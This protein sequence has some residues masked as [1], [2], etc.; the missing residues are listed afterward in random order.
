MANFVYAGLVEG[1]RQEGYSLYFPD[2]PGC[3]TAGDTLHELGL[4][5]GEA[6]ALHLEG[7][8]EDGQP[9]PEA[10]D[11]SELREAADHP[12]GAVMLVPAQLDDTPVRVNVSIPTSMLSRID[13]EAEA[14]GMTRSGFLVEGARTILRYRASE[15]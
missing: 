8:A 11:P 1:G 13:A 7:M 4:N 2:L 3:V 14:R 12:V 15:R 9:F 6:L 10:S 5:A